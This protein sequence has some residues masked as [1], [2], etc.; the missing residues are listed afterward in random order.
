MIQRA[1]W[2]APV[3]PIEGIVIHDPGPG[4]RPLAA[5]VDGFAGRTK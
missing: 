1:P 2:H 3:D 4:V 5:G